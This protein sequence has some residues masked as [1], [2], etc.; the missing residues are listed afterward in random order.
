MFFSSIVCP[1]GLLKIFHWMSL[2]L[3]SLTMA[4]SC[5]FCALSCRFYFLTSYLMLIITCAGFTAC[6]LISG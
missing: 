2:S 6:S 4:F 3:H 1:L 5:R